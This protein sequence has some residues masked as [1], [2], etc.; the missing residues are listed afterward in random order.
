MYEELLWAFL[1]IV[2]LSKNEHRI[3]AKQMAQSHV[4][5]VY[6]LTNYD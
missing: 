5:T 2:P 6:L 4:S 3:K 1:R